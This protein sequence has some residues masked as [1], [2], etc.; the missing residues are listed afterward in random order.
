MQKVVRKLLRAVAGY[1]PAY[2][3]MYA[4]SNEAFFARLY[5]ARM[6]RHLREAGLI[7]PAH[8]LDV[9]CQTGRLAIPLARHGF[10]VTGVD[11][12]G[13]ALRRARRHAARAGV[14]VRW[15]HGDVLEV[16]ARAANERFDA[17]VCAEVLYLARN[18]RAMLEAMAAALR[19]RG[20][21]FVSHRPSL[22]YFIEALRHDN[23]VTARQTLAGHEGEFEGPFP[24]RGYY[25]WQDEDDLRALYKSLGLRWVAVYPIDRYAWLSGIS[26]SQLTGAQRDQ[27]LQL[28]LEPDGVA[29]MCARYALVVAAKR[30]SG[31]AA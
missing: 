19:P 7:P 2:Y 11:T 12:S 23:L 9:G 4:D 13:F 6:L 20:V 1:D 31:A 18:Y 28:E 22:Y 30:E 14:S 29:A 15:W 25:N 16:L 10:Q 17:I 27:W 21:L 5:L 24:E 26:P 3:D 8:I